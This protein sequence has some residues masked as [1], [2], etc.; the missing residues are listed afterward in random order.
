MN[1][2]VAAFHE[3]FDVTRANTPELLHEVFRLRYQVLCIEQRLPGF[4]ASRY[5]DEYER[6][7]YDDHSSHVLLL[8]RPS[9]NFVGTARLILPDPDHPRKCF[10]LELHAQLDPLLFDLRT[11]PRQHTAEVSRLLIL[12]SFRQRREDNEEFESSAVVEERGIK[13]LRRFPH[14]ILALVA[15]LIS[16]AAEHDI[17]HWISMMDPALNRLLGHYGGQHDPIGPIT[18]YHGQRRPYH[19]NLTCA[20]GR[21][22]NTHKQIWELLTDYGRVRPMGDLP[23]Q[24]PASSISPATNH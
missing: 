16:V 9:G 23:A 20:L 5:P 12:R 17:T 3:Y 22:Y 10:P 4:D 14:P 21:M 11:V 8:H 6:D 19:L 15:G 13:K 24:N 7:N 18:E 2:I 1:D